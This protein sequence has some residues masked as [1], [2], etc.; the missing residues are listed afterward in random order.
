MM[1]VSPEARGEVRMGQFRD[2]PVAENPVRIRLELSQDQATAL[3]RI[4]LDADITLAAV[5]RL[6]MGMIAEGETVDAKAI[7]EEAKKVRAANAPP[8]EAKAKRRP[9]RPR[10]VGKDTKG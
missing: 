5:C 10:K 4:G 3:K 9:G 1:E 6:A 7:V 2:I 8:K